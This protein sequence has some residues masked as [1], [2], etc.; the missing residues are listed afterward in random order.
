MP[1]DV[2]AATAKPSLN[3]TEL[4]VLLYIVMFLL[5]APWVGTIYTN[6]TLV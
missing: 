6:L 5:E 2:R 4:V 3:C 1:N